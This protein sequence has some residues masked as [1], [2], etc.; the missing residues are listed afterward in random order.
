MLGG[1]IETVGRWIQ[2]PGDKGE[3]EDIQ[4]EGTKGILELTNTARVLQ[5]VGGCVSES[6]LC[7]TKGLVY[8]RAT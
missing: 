4:A 8:R 2:V 5:W 1:H 6:P 3:E 7:Q